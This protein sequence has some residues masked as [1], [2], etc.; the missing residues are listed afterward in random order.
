VPYTILRATQ[1]FEFVGAIAVSGAD[2]VHVPDAPMQPIAADDGNKDLRMTAQVGCQPSGSR[3]RRG[4]DEEIW[5]MA[6]EQH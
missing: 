5:T 1:F 6:R 4:D 3:L 2:T